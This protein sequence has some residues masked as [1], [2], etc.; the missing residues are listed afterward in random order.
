MFL[1]V[2]QKITM[3]PEKVC[4]IQT[5][6][7]RFFFY[8]YYLL[9]R[10]DQQRVVVV[11]NIDTQILLHLTM[12]FNIFTG[13]SHAKVKILLSRENKKKNNESDNFRMKKN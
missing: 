10:Q 13:W 8:T 3:V 6:C 5:D 11:Y 1:N 9:N 2:T 4:T 12:S 7:L